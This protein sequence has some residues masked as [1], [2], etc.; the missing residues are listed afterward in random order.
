MTTRRLHH[1]FKS[2]GR[3]LIV[4]M[5][6]GAL[7]GPMA[8]LEHPGRTIE[9]II[10]G[11]ADAVLTT[12]GVARAFAKELAPLGLILRSDGGSTGL[13]SG[14]GPSSIQFTVESALRLGADALAVCAYP[15][16]P[17]EESSLLNLTRTVET[18]HVWGM[19]VLA[20]MVPGGFDSGPEYR[21]LKSIS[22]AA[23]I[24]AELGADIIKCPY[25][26]GFENV[27]ATTYVPVVILGG[28]KQGNER[29]MLV[30]IKAA[31]D[32]GGAGVAVGRNI[33]QATDTTRMTSAVA[34]ILHG[35]ASVDEAM[36]LMA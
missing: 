9:R 25:V 2:D 16:S 28:A 7:D 14:K 12:Y 8:G 20:E 23:R 30:K 6:H 17:H 21:T 5:D 18:A 10:A 3:A 4:A 34:A 13:G 19:A 11:G 24:G 15:G 1:L 31:V 22:A 26:D 32:A 35:G 27:T 33:W 29:D 36:R